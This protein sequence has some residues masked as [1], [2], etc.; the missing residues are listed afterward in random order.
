MGR[1]CSGSEK[2][3]KLHS[4]SLWFG[5]PPAILHLMVEELGPE[6]ITIGTDAG[7]GDDYYVNYRME[8]F[9][10]LLKDFPTVDQERI[11]WHNASD[12]LNL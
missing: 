10:D 9:F 2:I 1:S 8:Q 3:S 7:F 5:T 12:L 4:L 11:F 6:K